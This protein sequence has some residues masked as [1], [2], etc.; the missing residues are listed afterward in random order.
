MNR[1][2]N[3]L[4]NLSAGGREDNIFKVF[5]YLNTRKYQFSPLDI[6]TR[7]SVGDKTILSYLWTIAQSQTCDQ[8]FLDRI[9][10]GADVQWYL[11]NGGQSEKEQRVANKVY[12][13]LVEIAS[14]PPLQRGQFTYDLAEE[15][16]AT[17][18]Y[19]LELSL[20]MYELLS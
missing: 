8:A 20:M 9:K 6:K 18:Y 19:R 11:L 12:Q 7:V 1:E 2:L 14:T 4:A 3:K 13:N 5:N 10:A 17:F 15:L 16:R